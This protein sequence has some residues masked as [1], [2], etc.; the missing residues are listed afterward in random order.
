MKRKPQ[1]YSV[2]IAVSL[3]LHTAVAFLI[4]WKWPEVKKVMEPAPKHVTAEVI[5]VE[6]AAEKE[7]KQKIE[8]QRRQ[9]ER[10]AQQRKK[11]QELQAKQQAEAKKKEQQALK[12]KALAEKQ[13]KEKAL[14]EQQ[15]KEKEQKKNELAKQRQQQEESL[16][17]NLLK[18]ERLRE[19][20]EQ[21]E[22][23][24][25]SE[26]RA[27]AM[28]TEYTDQ[29]RAHTSS[30][31][32]YPSVVKP[33]DE[34]TVKIV[35]VPTGEVVSVEVVKSS[36]NALLDSSVLQAIRKAS[37]LPVPKDIRVFE[38]SFRNFTMKFRPE[39]ALW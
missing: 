3:L 28:V 24:R 16:L 36:G 33:E 10:A 21:Q 8:K 7:R 19:Q 38:K 30:Y 14:A 32:S 22:A 25:Q 12:E 13:A 1:N 4:L 2:A 27:A 23:L 15:A 17:E 5:Q 26:Q 11:Q 39:N 37:P 20:K 18:E 9:D 34:V 6:S 29:I 35:L 31:W